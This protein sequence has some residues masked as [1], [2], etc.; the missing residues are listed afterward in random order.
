MHHPNT[1]QIDA[2]AGEFWAGWPA[3]TTTPRGLPVRPVFPGQESTISFAQVPSG[4]LLL[5]VTLGQSPRYAASSVLRLTANGQPLEILNKKQFPELLVCKIRRGADTPLPLVAT[6]RGAERKGTEPLVEIASVAVL[7]KNAARFSPVWTSWVRG[8]RSLLAGGKSLP[9]S[10][11]DFPHSHFDGLAYLLEHHEART[12]ILSRKYDSAYEY[13]VKKGKGQGHKLPLALGG[14]P[15]PGTPFNLVTHY[16]EQSEALVSHISHLQHHHQ[17]EIS[18]ISGEAQSAKAE[19]AKLKSDA[20]RFQSEITEVKEENELLLLQ[21][22]QVQ[23]ELEKYFLENRDLQESQKKLKELE[24]TTESATRER[25]ALRTKLA[26]LEKNHQELVTRHTATVTSEQDLVTRH[27]ALLTALE[28]LQV[29]LSSLAT[30]RTALQ[31]KITE[32]ENTISAAARERDQARA[33]RDNVLKERDTLKK[34]V[35]DRAMRI[36]ELEAQ[37]ADQ[38]ERQKQIDEE[39]AKAEG[40]LEMLKEL[41]RPALT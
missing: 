36:A 4:D 38:A 5:V 27:S 29:Q 6:F 20:G 10:I 13:F 22:H 25:D 23:E 16:R 32:L 17:G 2:M 40:Q 34:T 37:V 3:A 30:E 39:M 21:L 9:W 41:L 15:L 8:A 33:E 28:E 12:G 7:S 35:S 26:E 1:F 14:T 19:A 18:R 11:E 24:A 31:A